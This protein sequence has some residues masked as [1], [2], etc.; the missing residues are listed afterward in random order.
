MPSWVV[1]RFLRADKFLNPPRSGA[2]DVQRTDDE[3]LP[4]K[5][6][7]RYRQIQ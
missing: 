5:S 3:Q 4:G 6:V 7:R 1:Y 2:E